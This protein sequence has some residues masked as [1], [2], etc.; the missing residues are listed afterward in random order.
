MK[1]MTDPKEKKFNG[2][3]QTGFYSA[4]VSL[5]IYDIVVIFLIGFV[6]SIIGL[7]SY[8]KEIHKGRWQGVI[9]AIFNALYLVLNVVSSHMK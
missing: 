2:F 7:Y 1:A 6:V 3:C 8:R 4:I 5:F 9:G